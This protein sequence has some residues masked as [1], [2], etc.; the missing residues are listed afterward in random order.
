MK[1]KYQTLFEA[2]FAK[3]MNNFNENEQTHSIDPRGMLDSIGWEATGG[4][5]DTPYSFEDFDDEAFDGWMESQGVEVVPFKK[6]ATE[7]MNYA[8]DFRATPE[9][10]NDLKAKLIEFGKTHKGKTFFLYGIETDVSLGV[11]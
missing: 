6:G 4:L 10:L 9:E 8:K 3:V 11:I 5:L 1:N 2:A 7:V